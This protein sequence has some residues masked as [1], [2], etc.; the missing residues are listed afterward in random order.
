M[1]SQEMLDNSKGYEVTKTYVNFVLY[2][3]KL[4]TKII[5]IDICQLL[6]IF[7][8]LLALVILLFCTECFYSVLEVKNIV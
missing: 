8:I 1:N 2:V 6:N 3:L 5:K 4:K 7:C